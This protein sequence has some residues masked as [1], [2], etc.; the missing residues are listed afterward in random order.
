MAIDKTLAW[1]AVSIQEN[2]IGTP[3]LIDPKVPC[4]GGAKTLVRL[5]CMDEAVAEEGAR[6]FDGV[7]GGDSRSIINHNHL[8]VR[9]RLIRK[10]SEYHTQCVGTFV[11]AH[12]DAGFIDLGHRVSQVLDTR[13][14]CKV[15]QC[16]SA[17]LFHHLLRLDM[18]TKNGKS[19]HA[20]LRICKGERRRTFPALQLRHACA[21]SQC[22]ERTKSNFSIDQHHLH[23]IVPD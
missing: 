3:H 12:D 1:H 8:E 15:S 16:S 19:T 2:R 7:L 6:L 4:C 17:E 18:S 9:A 22:K 10:P 13:R 21:T 14:G 23:Q 20:L 11:G 5:P